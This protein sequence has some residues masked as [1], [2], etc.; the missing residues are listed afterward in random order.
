MPQLED[1]GPSILLAERYLLMRPG[2]KLWIGDKVIS[3]VDVQAYPFQ[4]LALSLGL[5][6]HLAAKDGMD[7]IG[8]VD[9]LVARVSVLVLVFLLAIAP[10]AVAYGLYSIVL[11]ICYV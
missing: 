10:I 1:G 7:D 5:D 9:V 4:K 2:W 11:E 3:T 8:Q 6:Q